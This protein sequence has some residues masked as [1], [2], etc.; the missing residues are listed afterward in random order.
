MMN[1]QYSSKSAKAGFECRS[2]F[3]FRSCVVTFLQKGKRHPEQESNEGPCIKN[4]KLIKYIY[5]NPQKIRPSVI[6]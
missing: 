5:E 3:S 1:S 6:K 4:N 2:T